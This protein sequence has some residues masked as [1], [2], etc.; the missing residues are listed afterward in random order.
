LRQ[1]G[2]GACQRGPGVGRRRLHL[3]GV[4]LEERLPGLD[5]TAFAEQALLHDAR[6]T[7]A[8]LGHAQG[9]QSPRQLGDQ[10]DLAQRHGDHAHLGRGHAA[11]AA[12]AAR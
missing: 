1:V 8:H 2:L 7:R 9:L 5:V 3:R 10:A 6:G 11:R 4:D 12:R